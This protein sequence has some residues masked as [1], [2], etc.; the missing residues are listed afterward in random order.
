MVI[1]EKMD[2][3]RLVPRPTENVF[4]LVRAFNTEEFK[5]RI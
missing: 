4:P 2:T 1:S 5:F 3:N